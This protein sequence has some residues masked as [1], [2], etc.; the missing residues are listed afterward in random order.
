MT[1]LERKILKGII[2]EIEQG[3]FKNQETIAFTLRAWFE[4]SEETAR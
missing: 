1:S 4:N 3:L 2:E